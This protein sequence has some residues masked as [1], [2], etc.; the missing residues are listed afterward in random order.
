MDDDSSRIK[1]F[2]EVVQIDPNLAAKVLKIVNSAYFGFSGRIDTI[3]RAL[4]LLGLG[5][6]HNLVLGVSAVNS[7]SGISSDLIDMRMFWLRNLYCGVLSRLFAQACKFRESEKLYVIGLLHEVG[8]LI[9]FKGFPE[10]STEAILR[11][12]R[13][14]RPLFQV[15]W[16]IIGL[17][18]GQV[19]QQLM[20][21]W[22]LPDDFQ[23]ITACHTEP[24]TAQNNPLEASI[25]HIA[26][27]FSE[28]G[29]SASDPEQLV[30]RVDPFA[31]KTTGLNYDDIS[32]LFGEG[33]KQS[34]ELIKLIL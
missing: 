33:I 17:D 1:N 16:E 7:F 18:Y 28:T 23:E 34:A 2:A 31:W 27:I 5:Q 3:T 15:E 10:Q 20:Q 19:G 30:D 8:H 6:L 14:Q 11:A 24:E 32:P 13:E 4:N 12:D 25:V 26:H 9:L 29:N 21:A 22:K